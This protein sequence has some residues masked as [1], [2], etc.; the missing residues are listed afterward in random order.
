MGKELEITMKSSIAKMVN[1]HVSYSLLKSEWAVGA[2]PLACVIAFPIFFHSAPIS[3]IFG[4]GLALS[5]V[6]GS[7]MALGPALKVPAR[8]KTMRLLRNNGI[9]LSRSEKKKLFAMIKDD[10]NFKYDIEGEGVSV[11]F[12][13]DENSG[14]QNIDLETSVEKDFNDTFY[15]ALTMKGDKSNVLLDR[16]KYVA[17]ESGSIIDKDIEIRVEKLNNRLEAKYEAKKSGYQG[18]RLEVLDKG[19]NLNLEFA[20]PELAERLEVIKDLY[21]KDFENRLNDVSGNRA[22]DAN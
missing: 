2:F 12:S 10:K 11:A 7:W 1:T 4:V 17:L 14:Q 20:I 22:V 6:L 5:L 16:T 9:H 15:H 19:K 21:R 13:H 8:I 3:Q 18:Y